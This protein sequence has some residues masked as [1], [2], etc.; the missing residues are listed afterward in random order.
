MSLSCKGQAIVH[1]I[2]SLFTKNK[3]DL[4]IEVVIGCDGTAT[5]TG[6]RSGVNCSLELKLSR[7]LVY[8]ST[9]CKPATSQSSGHYIRRGKR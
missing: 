4:N 8:M 6:W 2:Y 9:S 7:S 1:S 3:L 5:D